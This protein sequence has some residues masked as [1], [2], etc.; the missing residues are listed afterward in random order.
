MPAAD[1]LLISKINQE[2]DEG[3][4]SPSKDGPCSLP[5]VHDQ[6]RQPLFDFPPTISPAF[7]VPGEPG[8]RRLHP[9]ASGVGSGSSSG[10]GISRFFGH[11]CPTP[12]SETT[13]LSV[14]GLPGPRGENISSSIGSQNPGSTTTYQ[15]RPGGFRPT[16]AQALIPISERVNPTAPLAT[17]G[18]GGNPHS[19]CSDLSAPRGF[20]RVPT[21]K[22]AIHLLRSL[23]CNPPSRSGGL[24]LHGSYRPDW[25][26]EDPATTVPQPS[27]D[28]QSPQQKSPPLNAA[29]LSPSKKLASPTLEQHAVPPHSWAKVVARS[30]LFPAP[31]ESPARGSNER[32]VARKFTQQRREEAQG[33]DGTSGAPL[34]SFG[35]PRSDAPCWSPAREEERRCCRGTSFVQDLRAARS[36]PLSPVEQARTLQQLLFV[37]PPSDAAMDTAG[38]SGPQRSRDEPVAFLHV[39]CPNFSAAARKEPK[40]AWRHLLLSLSK[41]PFRRRGLPLSAPCDILPMSATKAEIFIPEDQLPIYR[42]ALQKYVLTDPSPLTERDFRRRAAAYRNSYYRAYRQATLLGFPDKHLQF[43]LLVHIQTDAYTPSPLPRS[44]RTFSGWWRWI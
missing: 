44:T 42:A 41:N 30:R 22:N 1:P 36:T 10:V 33:W 21:S 31:T 25:S 2:Q 3:I 40:A 11:G 15:R 13:P 19:G 7:A 14:R 27:S 23:S 16:D 43:D 6:Q 24:D 12:I 8:G 38:P 4:R 20:S 28:L 29:S 9:Q 32:V 26:R 35:K 39:E 18:G 37:A 17:F 34:D 5:T